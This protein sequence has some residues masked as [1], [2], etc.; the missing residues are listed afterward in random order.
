MLNLA[1]KMAILKSG[2]TQARIAQNIGI[3][4]ARL[5]RI[6]QGYEEASDAEKQAIAKQIKARVSE[7]W[8]EG[9]PAATGRH[10]GRDAQP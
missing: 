1:L 9:T 3:G 7:L 5:S 4:D 8:P 2:K 6:V 10:G